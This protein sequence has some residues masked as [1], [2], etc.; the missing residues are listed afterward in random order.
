MRSGHAAGFAE[1]DGEPALSAYAEQAARLQAENETLRAEAAR[2]R[3]ETLRLAAINRVLEAR[4][5]IAETERDNL[6]GYKGAVERSRP[7]R[8]IQKLRGLMGRRW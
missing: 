6:H 8:A 1:R 4:L 3:D 7:W 5:A 2:L